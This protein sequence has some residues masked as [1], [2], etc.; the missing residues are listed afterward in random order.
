MSLY[1]VAKPRARVR[2]AAT[3]SVVSVMALMSLIR[4]RLMAM[5]CAMASAWGPPPA[6]QD[7]VFG[8]YP[9]GVEGCQE[10]A[11]LGN[12][13][14]LGVEADLLRSPSWNSGTPASR[15]S[16]LSRLRRFR[17]W[18]KAGF[19]AMRGHFLFL[20]RVLGNKRR[21]VARIGCAMRDPSRHSRNRYRSSSAEGGVLPR[22]SPAGTQ[23][24][25]DN[26]YV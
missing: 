11:R 8:R 13:V 23:C 4:T 26:S 18:S 14:R 24:V 10:G 12:L 5:L 1:V 22:I 16:G 15:R 25:R 7:L 21:S 3:H 17:R 6:A 20:A 9:E 2:S 19:I